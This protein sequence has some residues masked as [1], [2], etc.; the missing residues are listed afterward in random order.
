MRI[1][2]LGDLLLDVVVRLDTALV[3]GD[4]QPAHTITGPGGQAANVAA[5]AAALGAEATFVGRIGADPA[6]TLVLAALTQGGVTHRGPVEGRTGVVVSIASSGDR[7]MASDRGNAPELAPHD[8]ESAWFDCDVLHVSGY[9]L[10][11]EP[12]AFAAAAAAGHA[13]AHGALV[14]L[15]VSAWT[16]VDDA[17]RDRIAALA[18]ELVFATEREHEEVGKLDVR[19]VIKRGARGLSVDGNDH[20]A[21]DVDVVDTTGAGDALA[22]GFLVGGAALGA[23]TAAR[24]CAQMGA[25][26]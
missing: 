3:T 23:S 7:T 14:S 25:M 10:A 15:D 26:P 22:A 17:F 12:I 1:V 11:R 5:W 9:A 16:L 24:C 13:R 6:G 4:D 21:V 2:T 20:P 8:L 18:P 19:W